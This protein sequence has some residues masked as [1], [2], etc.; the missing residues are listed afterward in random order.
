MTLEI[1]HRGCGWCTRQQSQS[2]P[3]PP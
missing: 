3:N 1:R 2:P